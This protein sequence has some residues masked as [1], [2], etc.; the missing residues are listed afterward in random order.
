M[1]FPSSY[2][3]FSFYKYSRQH[4]NRETCV[5]GGR[6]RDFRES[7]YHLKFIHLYIGFQREITEFTYS[8]QQINLCLF[9]EISLIIFKRDQN[10]SCYL[11]V[12]RSYPVKDVLSHSLKQWIGIEHKNS[13]RWVEY[14]TFKINP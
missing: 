8:Y 14:L 5:V 4:L 6:A 7:L 3:V 1:S 13:D 11:L 12:I 9:Y 10:R 2:I